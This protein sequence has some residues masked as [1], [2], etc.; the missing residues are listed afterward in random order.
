METVGVTELEAKLS[1]YLGHVKAGEEVLV[2]E[3]GRPIARL[4]PVQPD[5]EDAEWERLR[6]LER[7]G[8]VKLGARHPTFDLGT[9]NLPDDPSNSVRS[10]LIEER[11]EDR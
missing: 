5:D 6:A 8:V 9:L 3:G 4:V 2:T 10:A 11:D 1:E 7:Q